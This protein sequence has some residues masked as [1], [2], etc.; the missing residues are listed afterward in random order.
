MHKGF[1][2]LTHT[3][4]CNRTP[5]GWRSVYTSKLVHFAITPVGYES[6][7]VHQGLVKTQVLFYRFVLCGPLRAF[8][9]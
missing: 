2:V 3:L 4:L 8:V 9:Y 6:L 7:M 1:C 5:A